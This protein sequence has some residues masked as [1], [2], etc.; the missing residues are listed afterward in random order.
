MLFKLWLRTKNDEDSNPMVF[1]QDTE[2][3]SLKCY[4]SYIYFWFNV[5]S[6]IYIISSCVEDFNFNGKVKKVHK[7]LNL[8]EGNNYI[9]SFFA[10]KCKRNRIKFSEYHVNCVC[11]KF[12]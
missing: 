2:N 3:N 10:L 4:T 9:W 8:M 1:L 6:K 12:S 7:L 5:K 11:E